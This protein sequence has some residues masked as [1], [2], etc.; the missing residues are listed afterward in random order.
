VVVSDEKMPGMSGSRFLSIVSQRYPD[1][2]R[3]I[4]TGNATLETAI[5]AINEG[6]IYRFLTKPCNELD[7]ATTI[8]QALQ[9]K[10]LV[11]KSRRLL[12]KSRCQSELLKELEKQ[13][14][15]ITATKSTPT[16]AIIM[17]EDIDT[18]LDRLVEEINK[19]LALRGRQRDHIHSD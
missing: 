14:P 8:R 16:N 6:K 3:I 7:L 15:E 10:D 17:D 12:E 2:V 4:L 5:R 9:L 13:H 1:T 19:S 11:A 18:D